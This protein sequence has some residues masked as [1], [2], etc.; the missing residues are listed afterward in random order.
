MFS[1][2]DYN[3]SLTLCKK[4]SKLVDIMEIGYPFS[5][6]LADGPVIQAASTYALKNNKITYDLYF[7]FVR[8]I[9]KENNSNTI[10]RNYSIKK[11]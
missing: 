2:P 6:P 10:I 5:D 1:Y 11:I 8:E 9:L 7:R 4:L 3:T